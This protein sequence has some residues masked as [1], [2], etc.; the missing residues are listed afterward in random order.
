MSDRLKTQLENAHEI[1]QVL[2]QLE[3]KCDQPGTKD[4]TTLVV[5]LQ[6]QADLNDYGPFFE[7]IKNGILSNFVF[8]CTE[9]E[10]KIGIKGNSSPEKLLQKA[11]R[12]LSKHTA[13]G[14]LGELILYT[15][16]DVYFQ[17]PKLL[18]KVCMKTNPRMPVF[19]AD[20]VHGQYIDGQFKLYLGESKIHKD[21][22]GAATSASKSI[23]NAKLKYQD[24][25]DL[26]DSHMDFPNITQDLEDK[27]L[28]LLDPFENDEWQETIHS[29]CFIGFTNPSVLSKTTTEDQFLK[30]YAKL[31]EE[32]IST[33]S[34]KIQ[35]QEMQLSEVSLLILPFACIDQLVNSFIDHMGIKN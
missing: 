6:W 26:L 12:K 33:F 25:F 11:I 34:E 30:E 7:V 20:A 2:R 23:K 17:A 22:V 32:Y 9:V 19:G 18:S 10:K 29:P 15:L 1:R 27:L 4:L 16:L 8:S 28:S 5:F 35:T 24:E 31:A 21:F 3:V 14:E 13:K